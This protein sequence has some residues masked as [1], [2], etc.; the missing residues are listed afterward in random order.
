MPS[1]RILLVLLVASLFAMLTP[2]AYAT[3]PDSTW[4]TGYWDDDDFDDAI[5]FIMVASAIASI[6]AVEAKP[7]FALLARIAATDPLHQPA[8]LPRIASARAPP[9]ARLVS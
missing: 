6:P 1:R 7:R 2:A 3:P 4:M 5:A 9:P 8:P